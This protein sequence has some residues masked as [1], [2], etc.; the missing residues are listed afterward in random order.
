MKRKME[1][2]KEIGELILFWL[3]EERRRKRETFEI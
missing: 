3:T 1:R 2:M